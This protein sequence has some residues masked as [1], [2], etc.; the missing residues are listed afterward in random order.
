MTPLNV[1]ATYFFRERRGH[2]RHGAKPEEV[3]QRQRTQRHVLSEREPEVPADALVVVPVGAVA[4]VVT[5]A[6]V[7]GD[8]A[9]GHP[10]HFAERVPLHR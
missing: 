8:G 2:D 10:A 3:D 6:Q 5:A 4:A 7:E 9:P 1:V